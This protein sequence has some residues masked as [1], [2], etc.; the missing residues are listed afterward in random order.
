[1]LPKSCLCLLAGVLPAPLL[2]QTATDGFAW[3]ANVRARYEHVDDD[4]F[5][6]SGQAT[7]ARLRLGL[8]YRFDDHW[9]VLL[10]GVGVVAAGDHDDG[11]NARRDLPAITDPRAPAGTSGCWRGRE[12]A[13]RQRS[14]A[15]GSC[16]PTS[17]GSATAA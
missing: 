8:R 10:E 2:A 5:V 3:E 6:D 9:S 15:S 11:T 14:A 7:T 13:G 17:A 16:S 12:N 1:M 4:A